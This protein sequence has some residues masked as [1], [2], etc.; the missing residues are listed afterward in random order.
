M[1]RKTLIRKKA[2]SIAVQGFTIARAHGLVAAERG[3]PFTTSLVVADRFGKRHADVLRSI[4]NI[5]KTEGIEEFCQRSFALAKYAARKG[6]HRNMYH[7]TEEGFVLL[8]MGFTGQKAMMWKTKFIE[9]FR[10]MAQELMRLQNQKANLQWQ[11]ART[12]GKHKR[13]ELTDVIRD[14]VEY[15]KVQ[16]SEHPQNYYMLLS[17]CEYRALFIID[18][19]VGSNFRDR[20]TANQLG[21]LRTAEDIAEKALADGMAAGLGYKDIYLLAKSRLESFA[22]LVGKSQP[23]AQR[24]LMES[25]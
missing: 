8:V 11:E 16:G 7:M 13:R 21:N 19:A 12:L 22:E 2:E 17:K 15:A 23:G 25:A 20:L 1:K 3:E 5:L 6:E 4:E 14:F 9:A 24:A 10:L 18:H